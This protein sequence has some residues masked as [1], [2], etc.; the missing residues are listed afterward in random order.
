MINQLLGV[1][2]ALTG[3]FHHFLYLTGEWVVF[4]LFSERYTIL[5]KKE[6]RIK[7]QLLLRV[8]ISWI[9]YHIC[10][11]IQR[12]AVSPRLILTPPWSSFKLQFRPKETFFLNRPC[13]IFQV[14]ITRIYF[15]I[16]LLI[17]SIESVSYCRILSS[18][19]VI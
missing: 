12:W 10:Y 11:I 14:W 1:R 2:S 9:R 13:R 7:W 18:G 17:A 19:G 15:L 8:K 5:Q 6:I 16:W 3:F 4:S